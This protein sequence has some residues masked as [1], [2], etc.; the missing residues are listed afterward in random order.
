M[1]GEIARGLVGD[2]ARLHVVGAVAA[3]LEGIDADDLFARQA[4]GGR[5]LGIGALEVEF[6]RRALRHEAVL[7]G[8][9]LAE[10]RRSPGSAAFRSARAGRGRIDR[11]RRPAY[12]AAAGR[13]HSRRVR[14]GHAR[15]AWH[16]ARAA[17]RSRHS[18][19]RRLP[20]RRP[21]APADIARAW[22]DS[23]QALRRW[24]DLRAGRAAPPPGRRPRAKSKA[25]RRDGRCMSG[26][27]RRFFSI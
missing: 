5:G 18:N 27:C 12:R 8:G 7:F 17:S 4:G 22:P 3:G 2:D 19:R 6:A 14:S 23:R 13:A 1:A 21:G 25:M 26:C 11:P 10:N 24:V 9:R 20:R 15:G 16:C